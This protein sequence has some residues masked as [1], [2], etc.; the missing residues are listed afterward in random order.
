MASPHL[1]SM[2]LYERPIDRQMNGD[3]SL[4]DA[5]W[6]WGDI[7]R[8]EVNEK[9]RDAPEGTF[10]VRDASSKNGEYTLTLTKGGS[11]KLIKICRCKTTG[12]YGFSDP[13]EF[14]S[15]K[16][17][18]ENYQRESLRGYN[19]DLDTRL[20]F[21]VSRFNDYVDEELGGA[22]A[23]QKSVLDKLQEV[24]RNYLEKSTKYD[25]FYDEYCKTTTN[26]NLNRQACEA[27]KT[28]VSF[29]KDQIELAKRSQERAFPHEKSSLE[30]NYKILAGRLSKYQLD[31]QNMDKELR[32]LI[33]HS[34][35]LDEDMNA[36]KPEIITL[37]KHRQQLA[38][39][40]RD[41]GK[42][43]EEI[44]N[45]LENWSVEEKSVN[46]RHHSFSSSI[47]PAGAGGINA[48]SMPVQFE[49]DLP[50]NDEK[51][52]WLPKATRIQAETMLA[53]KAHGTFLIRKA[54]D[55]Q[56]A[57][58]IMCN[59]RIEHCKIEKTERGFGFADPYNIYPTLLELVL[60]YSQHSLDVHNEVLTSTLKTPIG[61]LIDP[62]TADN[63]Y[64]AM[65]NK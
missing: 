18:V 7:T 51:T 1:R 49:T 27:F 32:E 3:P 58:S 24:N 61:T 16:E 19:K 5:E 40:L 29:F 57:L 53:G 47:S 43:K 41:H 26:I 6:Y 33:A 59:S 42:A 22:S 21:P 17:L 50:H 13:F 8:D 38:K 60:H 63:V 56:L 37:F 20:L 44:N 45:L 34:R 64:V 52:W 36:L 48:M 23:D 55:G 11:C 2:M 39:W 10:L 35:A 65:Q 28:T 54:S 14:N 31:Q 9:L 25:S 4:V 62:D 46:S 30:N 15:V 12:K